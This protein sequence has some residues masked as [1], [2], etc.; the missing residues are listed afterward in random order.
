M[1]KD[2]KT[3]EIVVNEEN[4]VTAGKEEETAVREE[5]TAG[6]EKEIVTANATIE[7]IRKNNLTM[8]IEA[9]GLTEASMQNEVID[10]AE[11][12]V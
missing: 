6:K 7:M 5:K 9:T 2:G 8:E 4:E 3:M 11:V 10:Q 1:E 12:S